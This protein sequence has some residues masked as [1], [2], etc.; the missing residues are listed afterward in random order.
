MAERARALAAVFLEHPVT[1]DAQ[2]VSA[3]RTVA[4]LWANGALAHA[5]VGST[6]HAVRSWLMARHELSVEDFIA[7]ETD[8]GPYLRALLVDV[9][10]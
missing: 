1:N 10:A 6:L 2:A 4:F 9:P 3:L 7:G 5:K 8:P